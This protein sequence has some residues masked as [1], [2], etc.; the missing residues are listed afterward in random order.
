MD[1]DAVEKL[2]D[3][4]C[5][6]VYT[7]TFSLCCNKQLAEDIVQEAF[8]KAILSLE[9]SHT[10]VKAWLFRVCRNLWIDYIRRNKH[11]SFVEIENI[12]ITDS[13]DC[14]NDI[15]KAEESI[16]LYKTI[17]T[18]PHSLKEVLI[19]YYF[20]E[21]SQKKIAEI[22]NISCGAVRVLLYRARKKLKTI[23]EEEKL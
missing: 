10:N 2:Y 6:Q 15:I 13:S 17:L 19:L 4:Y 14:I 12:N 5:R 21:L 23:L 22:M 11:L 18:M 20:S 8:V 3:A 9:Y 7:Y 16:K 1:T